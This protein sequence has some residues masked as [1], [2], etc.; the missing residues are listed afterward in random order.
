[1]LEKPIELINEVNEISKKYKTMAMNTGANFNIFNILN[2]D[3]R[4]DYLC[5]LLKE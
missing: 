3:Q 2:I 5:C 4:E 1:M